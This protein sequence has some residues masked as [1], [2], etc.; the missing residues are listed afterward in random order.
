MTNNTFIEQ[1]EIDDIRNEI[2]K[3]IQRL[4]RNNYGDEGINKDYLV[5]L[6]YDT[7][8]GSEYIDLKKCIDKLK[9]GNKLLSLRILLSGGEHSGRTAHLLYYCQKL[10]KENS[11]LVFFIPSYIEDSPIDYI[12][13]KYLRKVKRLRQESNK[14]N[15]FQLF[16]D[17]FSRFY[18]ENITIIINNYDYINTGNKMVKSDF[19]SIF[20]NEEKNLLQNVDVIVKISNERVEWKSQYKEISTNGYTLARIEQIINKEKLSVNL[21]KYFSDCLYSPLFVKKLINLKKDSSLNFLTTIEKDLE[22]QIALIG[23]EKRYNH[24]DFLR[25]VVYRLFPY[26]CININSININKNFFTEEEVKKEIEKA[27]SDS[28][29]KTS[30]RLYD[31]ISDHEHTLRISDTVYNTNYIFKTIIEEMALM[32]KRNG[33]LSKIEWKNQPQHDYFYSLGLFNHLIYLSNKKISKKISRAV[34]NLSMQLGNIQRPNDTNYFE[35][36]RTYFRRANFLRLLLIENNKLDTVMQ[37]IPD[38]II[39]MFYGIAEF[40]EFIG[41]QEQKYEVAKETLDLLQMQRNKPRFKKYEYQEMINTM[42]YYI[43]KY[44]NRNNL[45]SDEKKK[46]IKARSLSKENLEDVIKLI[47][48]LENASPPPREILDKQVNYK[49]LKSKVYGNLGAYY[50]NIGVL[51]KAFDY[52]EKS[53]RLK[54]DLSKYPELDIDMLNQ[55]YIGQIR[56][57]I[58]FGSYYYSLGGKDNFEK[59]VDAHK[60][61]IEIGNKHVLKESLPSYN[62]IVGSLINLAE[63]KSGGWTKDAI[64]EMLN[65]LNAGIKKMG[66]QNDSGQIDYIND[67]WYVNIH[68]LKEIQE[69]CEI[70]I[71]KINESTFCKEDIQKSAN[72]ILTACR[73]I[74]ILK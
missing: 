58:C 52:Y 56:S 60:L 72:E 3:D 57:Q 70:I 22:T 24:A 59:S 66:L 11:N 1:N 32:S 27:L 8:K 2:E 40:Y 35:N 23:E 16:V 51:N 43:I 50:Y 36:I 53:Y 31:L 9:N 47:E 4:V 17:N 73:Q 42:S 5:S 21:V 65:Y 20:I 62:R 28:H 46:Y 41:D 14:E 68:E 37:L 74:T 49:L 38:E 7:L 63:S 34:N 54:K 64:I 69:K 45:G 15:A 61:A 25:C 10:I 19:I 71:R 44:S 13:T 55:I 39:K 26:I 12:Y 30:L 48:S 6:K 29:V 67:E 33:V 18:N